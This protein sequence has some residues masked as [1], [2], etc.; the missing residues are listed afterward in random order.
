M[1]SQMEKAMQVVSNEQEILLEQL[2]IKR[3][4]EIEAPP[5]HEF[6]ERRRKLLRLIFQILSVFRQAELERQ[7]APSQPAQRRREWEK[8]ELKPLI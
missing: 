7:I 4:R 1:E 6:P 8:V 3:L 2:A 5:P